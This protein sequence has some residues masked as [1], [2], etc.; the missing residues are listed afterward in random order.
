M[1]FILI[2]L[3]CSLTEKFNRAILIHAAMVGFA[4]DPSFQVLASGQKS[5]A[6]R[7]LWEIRHGSGPLRRAVE[8][9]NLW[10][11]WKDEKAK[12]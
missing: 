5:I 4:Q 9:E 11:D 3:Q 1:S 2:P 7:I 8:A 10:D 6:D 12:L